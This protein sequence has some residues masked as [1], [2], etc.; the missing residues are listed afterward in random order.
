[1]QQWRYG[2]V[3]LMLF[4]VAGC[5]LF[6]DDEPEPE[7]SS[8]QA[9][10][11][12]LRAAFGLNPDAAG[13]PRVF[14]VLLYDLTNERI[15]V[16]GERATLALNGTPVTGNFFLYPSP[17]PYEPGGRY[18][19]EVSMDG[20]RV[21][22]AVTAPS[23]SD[24]RIVSVPDS[25]C[26]DEPLT[27]NWTYPEGERNDG[28]IM[29]NARGYESERLDHGVTSHTIPAGTFLHGYWGDQE[30]QVTS[31]RSVLYPRLHNPVD[32]GVQF[33][34]G[35]TGSFFST[36]IMSEVYRPYLRRSDFDEACR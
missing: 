20:E 26:D 30:I 21:D 34:L 7:V 5:D 15:F 11:F 27:I 8:R 13:S 24:I 1:M 33:G 4:C 9:A 29:V 28:A 3:L 10:D 2:V 35:L 18:R 19:F 14:A 25:L 17:V 23:V 16:D 12:G 32:F 36:F 6:G 31:I 22:G